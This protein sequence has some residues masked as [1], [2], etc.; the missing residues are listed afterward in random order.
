M[1]RTLLETKFEGTHTPIELDMQLIG[2]AAVSTYENYFLNIPPDC[3][4]LHL[5]QA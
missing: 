4:T 1:E 3:A 2:L 5:H